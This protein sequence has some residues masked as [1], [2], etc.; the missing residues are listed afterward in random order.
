MLNPT[1]AAALAVVLALSIGAAAEKKEFRYRVAPGATIAVVGDFGPITLRPSSGGQVIVTATLHSDKIEVDSA[2][3]GNRVDV[4]THILQKGTPEQSSVDYDLQVPRDAS[5][6]LRTI[7]GPVKVQNAGAD[8]T[9]EGDTSKVEIV[10]ITNGHLKVRTVSGPIVLTNIRNS[11]LDVNSVS[12]PVTLDKVSG[13]MV[14]VNTTASAIQYS[15]DC[16]AGGEYSFSSHS[17]NIEVSLPA[18]ASVD[19][20]ARSVS[21]KVQNDF[22]LGPQAHPTFAAADGRSF[23]GTAN[24]GASSVRLRTFSGTIRV[25]KQ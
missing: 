13:K 18:A 2:Q 15:G 8:L 23:G 20:T 7:T 9:I 12:G 6:T 11:Y 16:G 17:G 25:K 1:R 22:P 10:D 19:I 5:I 24:S 4:R 14:A 21:G 3:S